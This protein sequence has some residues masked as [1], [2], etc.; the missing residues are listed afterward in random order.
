[1]TAGAIGTVRTR[2]DAHAKVTG[3]A[4]YTADVI[5]DEPLSGVVL[6]SPH[7][8]AR[9][10][11]IDIS[12]AAAMPGVSA[13]VYS[14][15]VPSKPLDFGIKDQHLFPIDCARYRGEPV[16]A[17]AAATERQARAA[18]DAIDIVYE[19]LPPVTNIEQALAPGAPLVHPDW[20]TYPHTGDRVLRDNVCGY[21]RIR[22]GD[23]DAGLAAAA[24][25]VTSRFSF[26]P[27]LPGYL[28]PRAAIAHA[29]AGGTLTVWCGSQSP[30]SNRDEMAE[31]FD[32]DSENV[33]FINQ[34]VGGAFGGKILMAP[35]WYAAA[36]A[37][38]CD[39][40]VRMAWSRHEDNQHA[41]PRHGGTATFTSGAG[42]DGSLLAMRASFAF[43][44]GAYIGYGAGS[45]LIATML[46]SAPYRIPHLDLE[47]T[48]VYTNKHVAG[49][50]RAPGGPQSNFA[51]ELHLDELARALAIDPLEFRL[52][53]AWED[54]D[55]S[56]AGQRL[57][58]VSVKDVLR[59]AA[60]AVGW[61]KP[62]ANGTGRGIG[63]TWWFS[64]CGA[65][66]A[67]VEVL[68]DG[69][70]RVVS[71]NPEI[72]TG[73]AAQALPI[74]VA[75]ALGIDP[76]S[77]EVSLADTG[78]R[79]VDGGVHGSTST[80][81]AGQA[82]GAAAAEARTRLLDRAES[83]LEARR[84][85]LELRDGCVYVVGAPDS[86]A[87]FAQLT[88]HGDGPVVGSGT[89]PE[90]GDPEID[91]A[92]VQTHGFAAWPAA[93]FTATAAEVTV[94]P[95]TGRVDVLHLATAQDVGFSFN[96]AGV[97]GQIEGGAVQ[98]LGWALTEGLVYEGGTLR[99]PDFKHYLMPTALDAPRI[100]AL[101]VE[102][103][104]IEGP[105]GMKGA[106]EPPVTTPAAAIGNAIRDACGAVPYET[107]MTPERVWRA[108]QKARPSND[109]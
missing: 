78:D 93:S 97:T 42:A 24:A 70:V 61:S 89:A 1:M 72:G 17:V 82:V 88:A 109:P 50:V 20:R 44:T 58:A 40:P 52:K 22:R 67:R 10:R 98:G 66:E 63:A 106:G 48:L 36:L 80:F 92:L 26:S 87:T 91:D 19:P 85:D 84:D 11:S 14:G 12:R 57:T 86:K 43:D 5:A 77:V 103:P 73:S 28:E 62:Q 6:R 15:N 68:G 75:D 4:T 18:A 69:R 71:G 23:V 32:L 37:L 33:R 30:Y 21:N 39:R 13:V 64:T 107:P 108:L 25:V 100:T 53:N 101:I 79:A 102:C 55:V 105:R 41:F 81:S 104:S 56:P 45:A 7:A 76:L 59:K 46:A 9:I 27:G 96:P 3:A 74:I 94:D 31:F 49:P 51:K 90:M 99:D 60:A 2:G 16:A 38:R 83:L 65:S 29:G 34:F 47:A 8:F 35:E 54:G 95:E